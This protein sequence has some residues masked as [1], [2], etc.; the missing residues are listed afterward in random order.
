MKRNILLLLL[1][2]LFA[3]QG[4]KIQEDL[5]DLK[6]AY[7][8]ELALPLFHSKFT[9]PDIVGSRN[10][11]TLIIAP[12]GNMNLFY[13]S[14]FTERKA[15]DILKIFG[16]S[17]IPL[18][19]QDSVTYSRALYSQEMV[20]QKIDYKK[21][22]TLGMGVQLLTPNIT[23]P[24]NLKIWIPT[25]VKAGKPFELSYTGAIPTSSFLPLTVGVDLFGYRLTPFPANSDSIQLRYR[26]YT[27]KGVPVKISVLGA[28][29]NPAFNY[30]EG[31]MSKR[32]I[33]IDNGQVDVSIYNQIVKGDLKF[34][35]PKISVLVENSY[36]Y[37]M[38]TKVNLVKAI[39]KRGDTIALVASNLINDGFDF[40]YPTLNEVGVTKKMRFDFTNANSNI[41]ELL[42]AGPNTILYSIDAVANPLG[43]KA[44]G[45]M[46]D[47]TTLR[48]G[49]EV[50]IPLLG[51]A[52]NFQGSDTIRNINLKD[53]ENVESA[54]FKFVSDNELPV[55]IMLEGIFLDGNGQV[56]DKLTD[57]PFKLVESAK[58]NITGDVIEST[59][60]E[61][62]IPVSADKFSRIKE[63]KQLILAGSFSTYDQGKRAVRILST[64]Q[65]NLRCGL[66]IIPK[67]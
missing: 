30:V 20:I 67:I 35:D 40:P 62:F 15:S 53:L 6:D 52:S 2:A 42:N 34:S 4:C 36:G 14:N 60:N 19:F 55:G 59:H 37:P 58:V 31:F 66:K 27:T 12:D 45:F 43:L 33:Q 29:A 11:S 51:S 25:L 17:I 41:K 49:L 48:I 56:L 24:I 47:S 18:N 38:R 64:Q 28:V 63:A 23:D 26:A 13:K 8:P 16:N 61:T 44:N 5:N 50:N 1:V 22:T 7:G 32:D 65:V 57:S 39:S 10:A 54:E 3:L 21:G 9:M 46:T